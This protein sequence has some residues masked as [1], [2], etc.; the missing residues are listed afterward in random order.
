MTTSVRTI[1]NATPFSTSPHP[2]TVATLHRSFIEQASKNSCRMSRFPG[3]ING[4]VEKRSL[5]FMRNYYSTIAIASAVLLSACSAQNIAS[6]PTS[7]TG[8][9]QSS[10]TNA[11]RRAAGGREYLYVADQD[12]Y[13]SRERQLIQRF[14]LHDGIPEQNPS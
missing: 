9:A 12:I 5:F 4:R 14:L 2:L 10:V 7:A 11:Q 8:V 1:P 13:E 3:T 6:L